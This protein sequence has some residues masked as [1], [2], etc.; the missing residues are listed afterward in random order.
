MSTRYVFAYIRVVGF[1]ICIM[2]NENVSATTM[3]YDVERVYIYIN[4]GR[5]GRVL[6]W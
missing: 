4:A 5:L 3:G 6:L 2:V 1:D